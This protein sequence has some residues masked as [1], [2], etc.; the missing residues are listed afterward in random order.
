MTQAPSSRRWTPAA[1]ALAF[2]AIFSATTCNEPAEPTE[3]TAPSARARLRISGFMQG[4]LE[5]CGCAAGQLGGLPRRAFF[6]R[7]NREFDLL[8]EGG[9][10]VA[11]GTVLDAAKFETALNILSMNEVGY[12][13]LGLGPADVQLPLDM[14]A[15]YLSVFPVKAVSSDLVAPEG[16]EW[17]IQAFDERPAGDARVRIAALTLA[18][19]PGE[20]GGKFR[21]LPPAE[22]WKRAMEGVAPETFR[23]LLVHGPT[24]V[25]RAQAKLT[26]RPDLIVGLTEQVAEP[27]G[28][29]EPV[30]GVPLVYPGT[31]GRM[32]LD[33][34]LARIQDRPQVTS[35]RV[36]SLKASETSKGALEDETAKQILLAH[37]EQVQMMGI[38]EQMANVKPTETGAEYVGSEACA[39]CH[40]DSYEI[41]KESK[42]ATAWETLEKAQK[43]EKY[44]WPVTHYPDC[45]TCHVVGYGYKTGFVNPETTPD[46]KDVGCEQCHGPGSKHVDDDTVSMKTKGVDT[47]VSCHDFE[48]SPGFSE[49]YDE[50]WK[51]IA[52]FL[53]K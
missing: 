38:R 35:Y 50:R 28:Q 21:M 49:N 46:K 47:C 24:D 39:D 23:V 52:H 16:R 44:G 11:G 10:I 30:D 29:P 51:K 5:P 43:S 12:H 2:A 22:A 8:I 17:P 1:M 41:W 26:P 9:N 19:P 42:H 25:C 6:V 15:M 45:I 7:Q 48:Q 40:E 20:A 36:I 13:A 14:L 33:V 3:R 18:V 31:R 32:L 34:T 53:D 4:R 37:R 27:L